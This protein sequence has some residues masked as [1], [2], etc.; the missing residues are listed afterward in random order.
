M[1]ITASRSS[2]ARVLAVPLLL[3]ATGTL[4]LVDYSGGPP[5]GQTWPVLLIVWGAA[6]AVAHLASRSR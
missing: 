5:I 6:W 1:A 3:I 4:F 2:A